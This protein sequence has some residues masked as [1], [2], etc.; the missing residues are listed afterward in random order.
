MSYFPINTSNYTPTLTNVANLDASTAYD[1]YYIQIGDMIHVCGKVDINPALPATSTKLG[2]SLP[3]AS[4]LEQQG[5]CNG[6][7]FCPAISGQ[8]A[9]IL[10]DTTNNRAQME[11][12][13]GDVTNQ[14]MHFHFTYKVL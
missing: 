2:I 10:G 5:D 4:D 13:A 1:C 8:G 11:Y 14:T 7:A 6:T 3:I 12:I 9:S